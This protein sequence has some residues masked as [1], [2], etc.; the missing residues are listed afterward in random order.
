MLAQVNEQLA[1]VAKLLLEPA[2]IRGAED[3]LLTLGRRRRVAHRLQPTRGVR[4]VR[5][6]SWERR[7]P[8]AR[9]SVG[10]RD[11]CRSPRIRRP[12]AIG[13]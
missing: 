6:P 2:A 11:V 8:G 3:Q 9:I 1:I 12:G 13:S 7:L 4:P 10:I 5:R